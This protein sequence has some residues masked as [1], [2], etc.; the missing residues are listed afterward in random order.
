MCYKVKPI[1]FATCLHIKFLGEGGVD[2]GGIQRDTLSAL[3]KDAYSNFL[4]I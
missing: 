2:M 4:R 1:E 3:W